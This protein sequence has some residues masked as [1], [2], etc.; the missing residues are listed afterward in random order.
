MSALFFALLVPEPAEN[1]PT[2][3][4]PAENHPAGERSGGSDRAAVR[5]RV[6]DGIA[7]GLALAYGAAMV[8]LG[9][10]GVPGAFLPWPVDVAVGVAAALALVLRRRRPLGLAVALLPLGAVSVMA[11]GAITVALFTVAIRR[12]AR[13]V[14]PLAVAH[15]LLGAAYSLLHDRPSFPLWV[16]VVVRAAVTGAAIGWG[17]FVRAHRRLTDSLRERAARLEA[18]QHLRVE[19]ARLTERARIAREMHDVLAHRMSL[20]SLHAGALEVRT[21]A[22]PDEVALAAGAVR[23]SAHEA[24]EE[25]RTVIGVLRQDPVGR[26]EPPQPDLADLPELV[27]TARATGMTV[28]YTC[29]L[30]STGAPTGLG[31]TAYRFVQ[32]GLTNA[33]KHAPD[34]TV[35]VL[36]DGGA[37]DGVHLS[38]SNPRAGAPGRPAVPGAG[39]GLVGLGERVAL[40]GGRI[41]YG[42]DGDTFR[43]RAW[44]PWPA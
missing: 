23:R 27:E 37:G 4:R 40:A 11:T 6:A 24:L 8:P 21:D 3:P 1:R 30:P 36:L 29:R 39:M 10:A 12:P 38:V 20:V 43:L 15:V 19:Q 22:R 13:V 31:R 34:G 26:P 44:L 41:E 18:E 42:V 32:E 14:L 25:L 33:R 17:F 16:D 28:H 7:V 35:E 5:D 9:D 2:G